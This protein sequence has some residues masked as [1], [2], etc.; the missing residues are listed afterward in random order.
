MLV[1]KVCLS[2]WKN[3]S[4]DQRELSVCRELGA[5]IKVV[6]KGKTEDYGKV[7]SVNGFE[8]HRLSSRPVNGLPKALNRVLSIFMWAKYVR[9]LKPD[10]ISGHDLSGLA[11]GWISTFFCRVKPKLV[12]D[13]HEFEIGRNVKRNRIQIKFITVVERYLIKKSKF[14]IV[15]ND[16]IADEVTRI[17]RL[18]QRPVVV[19]N[20]PNQWNVDPAVCDKVR[21]HFMSEFGIGGG[22]FPDV[23][24][25]NCTGQRN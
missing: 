1:L 2:E 23:S 21:S 13:S 11:I 17:H 9:A 22:G 8:V 3:E 19:R 7:E 18:D 24:R 10:I 14:M 12:Y 16:S 15:V 4:R 6:A 20:I 5:D 25:S